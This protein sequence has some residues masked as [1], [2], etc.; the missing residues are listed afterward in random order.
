[1]RPLDEQLAYLIERSERIF[2]ECERTR[3]ASSRTIEESKLGI[4]RFQSVAGSQA[5]DGEIVRLVDRSK[6]ILAEC[7]EVCAASS[8][9]IEDSGHVVERF[10][11]LDDELTRVLDEMERLGFHITH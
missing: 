7:R 1:M 5:S 9:T 6:R 11:A 3:A 8:K 4:D 2:A 10:R